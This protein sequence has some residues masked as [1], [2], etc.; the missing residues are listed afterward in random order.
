LGVNRPGVTARVITPT[1]VP[2]YVQRAL[3]VAHRHFPGLILCLSTNG[4]RLAAEAGRL[5]DLA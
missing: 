3:A 1:E 5:A 2:A 4:L